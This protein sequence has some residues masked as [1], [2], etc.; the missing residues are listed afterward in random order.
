MV[1]NFII[2][3]VV[4]RS[5]RFV[6]GHGAVGFRRCCQVNTGLGKA[7][8]AFGKPHETGGLRR[9]VGHHQ[10]QGIRH[11]D[12]L[13]GKDH[14]AARDKERILTGPDHPRHPVKRRIWIGSTE[15]LD[16]SADH[17]VVDVTILIVE[18][19]PLLNRFLR[20]LEAYPRH[21]IIT[22]RS[23]H[24]SQLQRVQ[25]VARVSGGQLDNVAECILCDLMVQ[26]SIPTL[27]I[28]ESCQENFTQFI[29]GEGAELENGGTAH[30]CL[31]HREIGVLRRRPDKGDRA[32]LYMRKQRI[33][34]RLVEPVHLVDKEDGPL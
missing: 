30:Q 6:I 15:A 4:H 23:C 3:A 11:A 29:I 33:L 17:V 34:L 21:S 19:R 7:E 27:A 14:H 1:G 5:N 22:R 20:H 12:I 31:D 28:I 26:L 32:V 8:L 24:K 2:S 18:K 25:G 9:V 13:A 10:G 16:K